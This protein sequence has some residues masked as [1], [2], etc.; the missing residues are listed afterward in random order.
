[1]II[2]SGYWSVLV[3]ISFVATVRS[4]AEMA[5][6][7]LSSLVLLLLVALHLIAIGFVVAS[8]Q[9]RIIVSSYTLYISHCKFVY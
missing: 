9:R 8:E 7:K 1:M 4:G 3:F 6:G 2:H 5:D